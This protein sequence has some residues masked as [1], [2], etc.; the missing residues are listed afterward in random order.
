[1]A[2]ALSQLN[3]LASAVGNRL[4]LFVQYLSRTD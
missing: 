2:V 3:P 1:M 4:I